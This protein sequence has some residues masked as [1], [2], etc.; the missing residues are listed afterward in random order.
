M[1]E[2]AKSESCDPLTD[3]SCERGDSAEEDTTQTRVLKDDTKV[4][5]EQFMTEVDD[6]NFFSVVLNP[7]KDVMLVMS[8]PGVQQCS[9]ELMFVRIRLVLQGASTATV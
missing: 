4:E 3:P 6:S 2:C 9:N 5:H 8:S 7:R 1:Q